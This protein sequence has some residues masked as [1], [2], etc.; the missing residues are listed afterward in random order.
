MGYVAEATRIAQTAQ[1][2]VTVVAATAQA[3]S[4]EVAAM[5]SVNAQLLATVRVG[6]PP[7]R[8][9]VVAN[10]GS[11]PE[12]AEGQR[13][14]VKTGTSAAVNEADGCVQDAQIEFPSGIPRIYATVRVYNI[15][16]GVRMSA[17]WA[18]E[19]D[20]VWEDAFTVQQG[21][22]QLCIWFY[23]DESYVPLTPGNWSVR[24]FA[25]GFQLEGPMSFVIREDM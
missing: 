15:E 17:T 8:R 14:F 7:E 21:A 2:E 4:T 25:D 5:Q 18:Y 3:A 16:P 23:V 10:V 20:Q 11:T 9:V 19:G 6:D 1:V 22:D 24:L 13:W 12:G